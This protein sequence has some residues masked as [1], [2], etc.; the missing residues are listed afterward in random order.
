MQKTTTLV[1]QSGRLEQLLAALALHELDLVL[2][3][4]PPPAAPGS[5]W[6]CRRIARQRVSIVG[7]RRSKKFRFETDISRS[8]LILPGRDSQLRQEFDALCEQLGVRARVFAEVDDMAMMRLLARDTDA[9]ALL[10]SVVV[11]DEIRNGTLREHCVVPGLFETFYA[12]TM[13][14][15]FQHPLVDALLKRKENEILETK[16]IASSR[17]LLPHAVEAEGEKKGEHRRR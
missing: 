15:R 3:N 14:R 9:I 17:A 4:R 8:P 11:R 10:P 5:Q 13:D 2:S 7:R 1:L 6:K 12:I 16:G